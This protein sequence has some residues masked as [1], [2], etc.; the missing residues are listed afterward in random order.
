MS[1]DTAERERDIRRF[2][3][4]ARD[5]MPRDHIVA[6]WKGNPHFADE[7]PRQPRD[8]KVARCRVVDLQ[9][10]VEVAGQTIYTFSQRDMF[11]VDREV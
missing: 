3:V 4:Y 9:V 6:E 5:L 11:S 2:K 10:E 7:S 8:W 1:K